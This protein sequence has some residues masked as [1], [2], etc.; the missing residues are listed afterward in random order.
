MWRFTDDLWLDGFIFAFGSPR[1]KKDVII[2]ISNAPMTIAGKVEEK[3]KEQGYDTETKENFNPRTNSMNLKLFGYGVEPVFGDLPPYSERV[4]D[5][6]SDKEYIDGFL[7]AVSSIVVYKRGGH[8]KGIRIAYPTSL[9]DIAYFLEHLYGIIEYIY[10]F[11]KGIYIPI[12]YV[13]GIEPFDTIE[14]A[15]E[16]E[17]KYFEMQFG[18]KEEIFNQIFEKVKR[19]EFMRG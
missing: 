3:L 8:D 9:D 6:D 15:T 2:D 19:Q 12:K 4:L 16:Y 18:T 14:K 1:N 11:H 5:Y 13:R 17:D 7:T 10:P